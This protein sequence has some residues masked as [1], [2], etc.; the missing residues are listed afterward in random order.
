MSSPKVSIIVPVYNIEKYVY[1]CIDSILNQT[2]TDFECILVDDCSSDNSSRICDEY[3]RKDTRIK[4]IHKNIN[5]GSPQAR[6]SGLEI[7]KGKYIIFF[8]GD[9]WVEYDMIEKLYSIAEKNDCDIVI[10]NF[11]NNIDFLQDEDISPEIH[12]KILIFKQIIM[13]GPYNTS[14]CNKLIKR[15]I[16]LKIN[17]PVHHYIDDRVLTIQSIYYANNIK[18]IKD[19]LYHY[20]KHHESICQS[21]NKIRKH[22]DEFNNLVMIVDFLQKNDLISLLE[23]EINYRIN[24]LKL[25]FIKEK[26]LRKL[27]EDVLLNL[28]PKSTDFIFDKRYKLGFLNSILLF[29]RIKRNNFLNIIINIII[30]LELISK[31]TYRLILPVNARDWIRNKGKSKNIIYIC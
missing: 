8:D 2:Y 7:S 24:L 14:L 25:S 18:Y 9:D 26:E 1:E 23:S 3:A 28:Y 31:K 15:D 30:F 12:D 29:I 21:E 13:Y 11:F 10:C 17:F 27:S 20:R 19:C 6:K 5:V 16:Y 22:I 4:V